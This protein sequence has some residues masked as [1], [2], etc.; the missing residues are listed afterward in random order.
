MNIF[1]ANSAITVI[2]VQIIGSCLR[3]L[4]LY[5]L[6]EVGQKK[7]LLNGKKLSFA[8]WKSLK[9]QKDATKEKYSLQSLDVA[10]KPLYHF[11]R[12]VNFGR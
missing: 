1:M 12:F 5:W 11:K 7:G 3:Q 9:G 8:S 2:K 6:I 4:G 10:F